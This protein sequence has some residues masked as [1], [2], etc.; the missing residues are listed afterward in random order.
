[1][2][3]VVLGIAQVTEAGEWDKMRIGSDRQTIILAAGT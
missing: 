1:M 2:V 3:E